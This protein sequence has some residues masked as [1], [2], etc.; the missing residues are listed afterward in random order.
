MHMNNL[1]KYSLGLAFVAVVAACSMSTS[2]DATLEKEVQTVSTLQE[3][4]K[5]PTELAPDDVVRVKMTS[6]LGIR[7]KFNMKESQYLS[8]WKGKRVLL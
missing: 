3:A 8:I 1:I 5:A 4:A 6:G 7:V 2:M